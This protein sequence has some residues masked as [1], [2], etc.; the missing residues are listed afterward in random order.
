MN[1][2]L[3]Y[4]VGMHLGENT[5]YYLSKGF[6]V[7]AVEANPTLVEQA[8]QR[9]KREIANNKLTIVNVGISEGEGAQPFWISDSSIWSSFDRENATRLG[10]PARSVTVECVRFATLLENFGVPFFLKIDIEGS[11]HLCLKDLR[12]DDLPQYLSI[13]AT[14]VTLVETLRQ[15]GYTK[16]KCISQYSLTPIEIPPSREEQ[17][18]KRIEWMLYTKNPVVRLLRALGAK[19]YLNRQLSGPFAINGS[20]FPIGSSGP[21]GADLPGRW[22]GYEEICGVLRTMKAQEAAGERSLFWT[23][24]PGSFWADIHASR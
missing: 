8:T 1:R 18:L 6:E 11:D 4:D 22:L 20:T 12:S 13:E 5:E 21:F 2:N 14:E 7:L 15:L 17:R 23:S 3:I 19:S 9:F 16:F 10:T 24:T